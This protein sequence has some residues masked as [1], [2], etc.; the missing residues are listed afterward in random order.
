MKGAIV[1]V[2][3]KRGW[4]SRLVRKITGSSLSHVFVVTTAEEPALILNADV[5]GVWV[6]SINK[7]LNDRFELTVF[8]PVLKVVQ[9][10][11]GI[12]RVYQLLEAQYGF[13]QVVGLGLMALLR[14]V[15]KK[16]KNPITR[17]VICTEVV[18]EYLVAVGEGE[19]VDG[20]DKNS[21]APQGLCDRLREAK[22]WT[23]VVGFRRD[24]VGGCH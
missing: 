17:G 13:L 19:V 18:W 2:H 1:F 22:N 9:V 7:Y 3:D 21:L 12:S 11:Q 24:S 15:W 4:F 14:G 20:L 10:E 6:T 23:E 5:R 8:R 16:S